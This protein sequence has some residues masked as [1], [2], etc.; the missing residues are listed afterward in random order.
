MAATGRAGGCASELVSGQSLRG[1]CEGDG[2]GDGRASWTG[3]LA[4]VQRMRVEHSQVF[5]GG[6]R[7]R[8]H[9]GRQ[10]A[11]A[12]GEHRQCATKGTLSPPSQLAWRRSTSCNACYTLQRT[13]SSSLGRSC[14]AGDSPGG[15][16]GHTLD[17]RLLPADHA[18]F[19]QRCRR[20]T[21]SLCE[22]ATVTRSKDWRVKSAREAIHI[23]HR[24][25]GP[26]PRCRP[27]RRAALTARC[28]SPMPSPSLGD[29]NTAALRA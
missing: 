27:Q 11:A 19:D 29:P 9:T 16:K 8:I 6:W 12:T 22:G 20:C 4:C 17:G 15:C 5:L 13:L 14:A 26:L 10:R 7:E 1:R 24:R 18:G 3:E 25:D 2:A 28:H 23:V 21:Q